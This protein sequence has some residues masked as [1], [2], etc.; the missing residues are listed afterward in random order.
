MEDT[1]TDY[2]DNIDNIDNTP[3]IDGLTGENNS[4]TQPTTTFPTPGGASPV[5]PLISPDISHYREDSRERNRLWLQSSFN[6]SN[7]QLVASVILPEIQ[8]P[9]D[10]VNQPSTPTI[11]LRTGIYYTI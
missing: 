11:Q 4:P 8:T 1:E 7:P 2:T 5:P 3:L 10:Q 9:I 6:K